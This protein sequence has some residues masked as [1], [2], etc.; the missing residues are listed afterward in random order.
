MSAAE[1]YAVTVRGRGWTT[2]T[3][4]VPAASQS[5]AFSWTSVEV[6]L[7]ETTSTARS[8]APSKNVCGRPPSSMRARV[9]KATSGGRTVSGSVGS[10]KPTSEVTSPALC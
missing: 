2:R 3:R 5:S 1:R 6:S 4:R 7:G 8:G 9:M 10:L